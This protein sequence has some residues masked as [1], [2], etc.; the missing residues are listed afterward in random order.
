MLRLVL[1]S[2]ALIVLGSCSTSGADQGVSQDYAGVVGAVLTAQP[3][4][5]A[6]HREF[7]SK[8][9][10]EASW[11]DRFLDYRL[12]VA[13]E[14]AGIRGDFERT[15]WEVS[16]LPPDF[17]VYSK[18]WEKL[19]SRRPIPIDLLPEHLRWDAALSFCPSGV[20]RVGSPNIQG[21][22]ATVY[23]ENS[24]GVHGWAGEIHL[25]KAGDEWIIQEERIWW[26][27]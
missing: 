20:L 6:Q 8:N 26:E 27:A 25:V 12:C 9:P 15:V 13:P 19:P 16:A 1:L 4:V 21:E 17:S 10:D 23:M 7:V 24:S 18:R 2:V 5:A 3:D 11:F 22:S 14:T